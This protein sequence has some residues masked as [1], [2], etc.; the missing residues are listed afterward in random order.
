VAIRCLD[1]GTVPLV[2]IA[3]NFADHAEQI[4]DIL[5]G[6]AHR[7]K[8]IVLG[9]ERSY[10]NDYIDLAVGRLRSLRTSFSPFDQN[11]AEQLIGRYR[12]FGL[13]AD[14]GALSNPAIYAAKLVGQ[15]V[16]ISACQ[17]LNDF[18]SVDLIL[19]SLQRASEPENLFAFLCVSL[20]QY[21]YSEGVRYSVLQSAVGAAAPLTRIFGR[22]VPLKLA[23]NVNDEDFVIVLQGV[24]GERALSKS[25]VSSPAELFRAFV[26]LAHALSPYVNRRA[27][28]FRSPEARL[29]GRL[30][31]SDKV[32]KPLLH[33]LAGEFYSKT[34]SMWEWNSRYWEQ[35]ALFTSETNLVLALQYARHAVAIEAHPFALTTLGK[36]LMTQ[37][38]GSV[39]DRE[40]SFGEAMQRLIRA[41]EGEETRGRISLHPFLTLF[42]GAAKYVELGG[43]LSVDQQTSL[44]ALLIQA[45]SRFGGDPAVENARVRLDELM[46]G[47]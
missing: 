25:S 16:A 7:E 27:I 32:V 2:L 18:R 43:H 20:V 1:A 40:S 13:V 24:L 19:D 34:Q 5:G 47:Y 22:N 45:P 36:L 3:D 12:R 33:A 31:D 39:P 38:E 29:A 6:L 42:V 4:K 14:S 30:F 23:Y 28:K 44:Q 17:I 41:I 46:N 37:M 10:R 26:G 9:A 11:E 35:R 21:C 15:P 8:L